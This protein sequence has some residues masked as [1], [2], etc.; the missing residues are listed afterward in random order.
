MELRHYLA[1]G[2]FF[3]VVTIESVIAYRRNLN[4]YQGRDIANNIILGLFTTILMVIGKGTFLAFFTYFK[5]FALF[6]IGMVWWSWIVLFFLN[7]LIFYWFHRL[8][9]E[10]R[11]LWAF[12]VAHH[13]STHYNFSTAVRNNFFIQTFRYVAW[14]PIAMIGFDPLAIILMD[15]VAY[16]FQL[17]VHTQM[18]R[19]LGFLEWFLNTPSHHR[20]HHGSN[21][22]YIDKNYG[23]ILILW[24]RLFGT[25]RKEEETVRFGITRNIDSQSVPNILFHEFIAIGKDIGRSR[26]LSDAL[27]Y[28]FGHPGWGYSKAGAK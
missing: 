27:H 5:R 13:S 7:E 6:D 18:I 2:V 1:Y 28:I 15:S 11:I 8:S 22:E 12:H 4:L 16:F 23:A 19:N 3:I 14:A 17:F 26:S 20:V 25:F 9:H 21:P 24:D 10:I